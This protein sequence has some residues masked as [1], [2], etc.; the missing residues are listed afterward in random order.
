MDSRAGGPGFFAIGMALRALLLAGLICLLIL[1]LA[2]TQHYAT[3]LLLAL[4]IALLLGETAHRYAM[5]LPAASAGRQESRAYARDMDQMTALLDAV[6]VAL[7]TMQADGRVR[8]ANRAARLLAGE[9]VGRLRDLKALGPEAAEIICALPV[10]ARRIVTIADG[11]PMLV[12]VGTFTAPGQA[13]QKL[14]SLQAVTGELDAVQLKAWMDMSRVLSH[15][16]MNSLT[17]IASLSESLS[18]MWTPAAGGGTDAADAIAAIGRRSHHLM[19]FVERYRHI[20]D[21]PAPV[22]A[23]VNAAA[24]ITDIGALIQPALAARNIQYRSARPPDLSFAADAA[25]LAQVL[26]NLLHNAADAAASAAAPL[27]TLSCGTDGNAIVFAVTDNGPG[28]PAERRQEIFL[29]FFSTKPGGSG[30]GLTLA[31]QIVLAHGGGI[32]LQDKPE[33]GTAFLV[34]L[35][36]AA[37]QP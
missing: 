20:A 4:L 36:L 32:S 7:V 16:I 9:E 37:A 22:L 2:S 12:W 17:P 11:R 33:G 19:S 5:T 21:L 25:L 24:F 35:P 10:G 6:T 31:R 27:V 1:V 18:R 23:N 34:K 29:P 14:I 15:E 28:I 26:I 13:P 8:L 3:A 30:I